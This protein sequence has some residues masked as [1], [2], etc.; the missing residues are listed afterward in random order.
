MFNS[1][2]VLVLDLSTCEFVDH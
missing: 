2:Y 1:L